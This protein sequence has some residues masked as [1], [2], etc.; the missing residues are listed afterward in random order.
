MKTYIFVIRR[1]TYISG[2]IQYVYNKANYLESQGWRVL[3]FSAL[4]GPLYVNYFMKFRNCIYPHLYLTPNCFRKC[5]VE[6][7]VNQI[8][9][10]VGGFHEEY[11]IIE[12]DALQRSVWAELIASQLKCRHLAFFVRE[13]HDYFDEHALKYLRFKYSRHE[14]AGIV[15]ES[16]CKILHDNTIEK[17]DDTQFVAYCNNVIEDCDDNYSSLL[18]RNAVLSLGYLGRLEKSCVP[19]IVEGMCEYISL[20][21][22]KLFNVVMIGGSADK[23]RV[24]YIKEKFGNY[25]NVHLLLTGN[26]YPIP[27]SFVKKIDLF[28][29]SA[30]SVVATYNVGIPT[31]RVNPLNGNVIGVVGLDYL[32]GEKGLYD[33]I[34]DGRIKDS[35]EKAIAK[36][37]QISFVNNTRFYYQ[38][39]YEEFERQLGIANNNSSNC[40]FEKQELLK[41]KT[42]NK[43]RLFFWLI[44][45]VFGSKGI[46]LF[47]DICK[48]SKNNIG[49]I[50]VVNIV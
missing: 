37:E 38:K 49:N 42:A 5:V 16:I 44:G 9:N 40:H 23:K 6:N 24:K 8:V 43:Y 10:Q 15:A 30:G 20:H 13:S 28:I 39:M 29:S 46:Q 45:H 2:A 11:T 18:N 17:R 50:S 27:L 41:I 22:D 33:S 12:S 36:K 48:T 25:P 32:P 31:I 19:A 35:I 7:V 26:M 21:S 4:H 1:I 47:W 14:L 34:P 3:I